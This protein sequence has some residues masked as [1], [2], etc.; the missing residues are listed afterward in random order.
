M[1]APAQISGDEGPGL[2][3]CLPLA[4]YH[5]YH[6]TKGAGAFWNENVAWEAL[7]EESQM[8]H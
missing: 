7:E 8:V 6:T 2:L 1:R 5:L 4:L 3:S